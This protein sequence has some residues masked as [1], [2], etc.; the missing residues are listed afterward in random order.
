[1]TIPDS[2]TT[3]GASAF[4]YCTSLS[5]ISI[6]NGVTSIGDSAFFRCARLTAVTIPGSVSNLGFVPFRYCS[7][8]TGIAVDE[9][10]LFYSS[11]DGVLFDKS[12]AT[13]IEYPG[14]KAGPYTIPSTVTS[15]GASAFEGCT[16]ASVT[17]ANS[18]INVGLEAF[19]YCPDL[20]NIAVD[21]GNSFYSS[22]NGVLFDQ[23]QATLIAY[24]GA[25]PGRTRSPALSPASGTM[26]SL[27]APGSPG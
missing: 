24:P 9:G 6:G 11:A 14:G 10:S 2:V 1:M 12:Q 15:I 13:L 8:L 19:S 23:S 5:N 17:I 7:R 22:D 26:H 25:K 18:V 3:I 4:S 16:L 27:A 21:S 20:A